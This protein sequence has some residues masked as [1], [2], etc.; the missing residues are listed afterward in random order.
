M[1]NESLIVSNIETKNNFIKVIGLIT[2]R[3]V[4]LFFAII[5]TYFLTQAIQYDNGKQLIWVNNYIITD[6]TSR[7]TYSQLINGEIINDRTA[8]TE[9]TFIT[10]LTTTLS[11]K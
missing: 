10:Y 2:S 4:T 5:D 7:L 3:P 1:A 8:F 11:A 9:E 6:R